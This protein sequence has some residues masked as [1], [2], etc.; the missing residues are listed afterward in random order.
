MK[1]ERRNAGPRARRRVPGGDVRRA[2][3]QARVAGAVTGGQEFHAAERIVIHADELT[4]AMV[5]IAGDLLEE[6]NRLREML[7]EARAELASERLAA[8]ALRG[9]LREA[10]KQST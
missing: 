8:T 7:A 5:A 6:R 3:A 2:R 9:W 4:R 10:Q 1:R